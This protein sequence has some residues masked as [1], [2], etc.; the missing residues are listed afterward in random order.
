ML[1]IR[2]KKKLSQDNSCSMLNVSLSRSEGNS[3]RSK[4]VWKENIIGVALL[5]QRWTLALLSQRCIL[6]LLSAVSEVH[7]CT[8]RIDHITDS[9]LS[10]TGNWLHCRQHWQIFGF[11][12]S[13]LSSNNTVSWWAIHTSYPV[14]IIPIIRLVRV[15][16]YFGIMKL[17]HRIIDNHVGDIDT[18]Y[19]N[20]KISSA[21]I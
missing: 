11:S 5:S 8:A 17:P 20:E 6:A 12:F 10:F 2:L 19:I 3:S 21:K 14:T 4:S 7:T 13:F 15:R 18:N 16:K 9:L 1:T